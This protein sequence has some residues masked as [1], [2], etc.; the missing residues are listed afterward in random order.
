M[1]ESLDLTIR[2]HDIYQD[3]RLMGMSHRRAIL[4][5]GKAIGLI[6]SYPESIDR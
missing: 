2:F 1:N 6:R 4:I 3:N 5:A